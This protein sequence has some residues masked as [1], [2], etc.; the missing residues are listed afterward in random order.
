MSS[1][2]DEIR[3]YPKVFPQPLTAAG[4]I[5]VIAHRGA[6]KEAPENTLPAFQLAMDQ[7]ADM[8][9]LDVKTT[10][11]GQIVI[12]HDRFLRRTTNGEGRI[13]NQ[14]LDQLKALDAGS[15]FDP[16]RFANERIPTLREVLELTAGKIMLNLEIKK[17][18]FSR[19]NDHFERHLIALLEEYEMVPHT[20]VSSFSTL[21]LIRIKEQAP[22]L[23]TALLYGDTIR[24]N[25]RPKIPIYG[26]QAYQL[27]LRTRADALTVRRNL[28]TR[29]F[30]KRSK[31]TGVR[32]FTFTVDSPKQ[33]KRMIKRQ[34][35][36]II[37][38]TPDKLH[39]WLH[40]QGEKEQGQRRRL[41]RRKA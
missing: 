26:Y 2:W 27:V 39:H 9:E 8:I 17:G 12:F 40:K 5:W 30:L 19:E 3:A 16:V 18:A 31:E 24:T 36:G 41:W 28:V 11:D 25:L 29:A 33:M 37:T 14:T 32:I 15:W 10:K 7:G 23:S 4:E 35:N 34:L 38:N 22:R 21:P 1:L 20:L 13:E 6:S